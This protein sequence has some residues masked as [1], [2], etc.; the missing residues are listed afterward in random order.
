[1]SRVAIDNKKDTFVPAMH[2][3][4]EKFYKHRS[5]YSLWGD[6]ESKLTFGAD[7]RNHVERKSLAG[8]LDHRSLADGCPSSSRMEVRTNPRLVS[9]ENLCPL[10][11]GPCPNH[12]IFFFHP[13]LH[14]RAVLLKGLGQRPL[15]TQTQLRQQS[16]H[17]CQTQP[18]PIFP[19]NQRTDHRPS[20]QRKG[21]LKLQRVL[22][23]HRPINPPNLRSLQLE[24]D[25]P[26]EFVS[27]PTCYDQVSS[28]RVVSCEH[29]Y[30]NLVSMST[31]L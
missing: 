8:L 25:G 29:G 31:Y 17:R 21:K 28:H 30:H 22:C 11:L 14:Q 13:L 15:A 26:H 9:K 12:R 1:M 18:H 5:P 7:C 19:P 24:L 23:G 10:P 2:Q 3:T 16:S 4:L 20:P 6:H 27:L